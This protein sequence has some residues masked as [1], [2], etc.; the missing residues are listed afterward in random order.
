MIAN[1]INETIVRLRLTLSGCSP[2]YTSYSIKHYNVSSTK[3]ARQDNNK[4]IHLGKPFMKN[5]MADLNQGQSLTYWH[6]KNVAMF[7]M[8]MSAHSFRNQEQRC[9]S[10]TKEQLYK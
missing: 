5:N 8:F 7:N 3:M 10:K 2:T 1:E 6:I 9:N 4:T